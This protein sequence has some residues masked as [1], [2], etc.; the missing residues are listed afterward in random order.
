[1]SIKDFSTRWRTSAEN[2]SASERIF[3]IC[4]YGGVL[5]I[6]QSPF[7]R[8]KDDLID[9]RGYSARRIL[10][11]EVQSKDLDLSYS[12]FSSARMENNSFENCLFEK[13]DFTSATDHG[14][15]F[16]D[17]IFVNCKFKHA[18]LG[19]QG[20]NYRNCVF[21]ECD[22]QRADFIRAEFVDTSFLNCR[23]KSIDFNAS[24]FENCSFE[25]LLDDVWF[26][27]TF[28]F[29]SDFLEFGQ[30]KPNKMLNVSFEKADLKDITFSNGCDLSTVKIKDNGRY[31]KYDNWYQR[32]QFLA[33]EVELWDDERQ[34][35]DVAKFLKVSM[36]HA[37]TQDWEI[38]S[39]DDWE[40]FYGGG[41]VVAK[42]VETLNSYPIPKGAQD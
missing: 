22:F 10:V 32:L 7:G 15:R 38:L 16:D 23:L 40:K 39:L 30:P 14:N 25:G 20:S 17:C 41:E 24:S 37:P 5:S 31:F 2:D 19:Y 33:Q 9:F 26:R 6:D 35:N 21:K 34:R 13:S 4:K 29:E 27:G 42:I 36:V 12:D 8:Q 28:A 1:M 3:N 11:K 18:I